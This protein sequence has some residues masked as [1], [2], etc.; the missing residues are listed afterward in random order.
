MLHSL[1]LGILGMVGLR[2]QTIGSGR[3]AVKRQRMAG[4]KVVDRAMRT[5]VKYHSHRCIFQHTDKRTYHSLII[6]VF[7]F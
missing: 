7:V 1:P 3:R 2:G 5:V 6:I 4:S